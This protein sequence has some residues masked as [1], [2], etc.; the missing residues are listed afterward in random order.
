MT[1]SNFFSLVAKLLFYPFIVYWTL[2][3]YLFNERNS[4]FEE[5]WSD[6]SVFY[7]AS[8][9]LFVVFMFVMLICFIAFTIRNNDKAL[10]I[11]FSPKYLFN[12]YWSDV[13]KAFDS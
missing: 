10:T 13:S 7:N 5:L 11:V 1:V 9:I 12:N 4:T 2:P 8:F 3:L 6:Q